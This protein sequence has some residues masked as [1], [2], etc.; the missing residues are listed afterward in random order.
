MRQ[1]TF[2]LSLSGRFTHRNASH[3]VDRRVT[4]KASPGAEEFRDKPD[5]AFE[6]VF[7]FWF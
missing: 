7:G 1:N 4:L 3:P 2:L 6:L 5:E